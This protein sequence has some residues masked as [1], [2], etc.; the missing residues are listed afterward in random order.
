MVLVGRAVVG[1]HSGPTQAAQKAS[2]RTVN[3]LKG[4]CV[5]SNLIY[6]V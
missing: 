3:S 4:L 6:P 1:Y 5:S 2:L